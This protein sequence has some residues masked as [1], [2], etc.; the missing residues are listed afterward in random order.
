MQYQEE[1]INRACNFFLGVR[2]L[3]ALATVAGTLVMW[4]SE[5]NRSPDLSIVTQMKL[6]VLLALV[7]TVA[8]RNDCYPPCMLLVLSQWLLNLDAG[9]L[10]SEPTLWE[11]K[12]SK[13]LS[14]HPRVVCKKHVINF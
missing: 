5:Q 12:A 11:I 1:D 14:V 7:A 9:V 4:L 3:G 2:W 6:L 10:R 8:A 13:C